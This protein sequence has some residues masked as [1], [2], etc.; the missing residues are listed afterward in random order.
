[1]RRE[2]RE[3]P[4]TATTGK[5]AWNEMGKLTQKGLAALMKKPPKRHPDGDGLFF[6][7]AGQGKAYWTAR[8]TV[9]HRERETSLGPYP[10]T[11]LDEA[12]AKHLDL[13]AS[14]ARK[15]DPVAKRNVKATPSGT[16]TF[17][18]MA[19][20]Y[21]AAHE[22]GWKN[23][24][25]HQQWVMTLR[26][27]AAPIRDL[28][29]D[30]VDAKAVLQV[31]EPKWREAPETMSRLRGRIEVVLAS[32][33]VAGHID[34]DKPNPARWKNWL[35]HM[36]PAPKKIGSRGH[37]AA[38]DYRDL[39]AFMAKLD[40]TPGDSAR[41]LAFTIL[42]CARTS[43]ALGAR[44]DEIDP[45]MTTW[46]VPKER[47]K[48]GKA[49]DVPLSDQAVAIL[50]AQHATRGDNPHVFPG[51]P[52]RGLS[53]MSMAMLMRR[54][55]AGDFTVHG[56]RSAARSW[57]ADQGVAFELAEAALGHQVGNAVVQAYQRSSM[58]ERRRPVL[59][60]WA[61]FVT[62]ETADNV[63]ELRRTGA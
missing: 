55:G 58:L 22:G 42:T 39:P 47:M 61:T 27:Y 10:E 35:D 56:M 5:D 38:M 21:I 3:I 32:A 46:R 15:V 17:G 31:L 53:N 4:G 13:R 29:V 9:G 1:M 23:A 8:Y 57:M 7:V 59:A 41:A 34:P 52:M 43:E 48:M 51:R 16:P 45:E 26:E 2:I 63:V 20:R 14:L 30:Q 28:P 24:K 40:Q 11:S 36:L 19:D 44:W 62:G 12:R 25:H 49:H 18:Q 33:Q 60:A 37:H 50:K 6:R 54:L